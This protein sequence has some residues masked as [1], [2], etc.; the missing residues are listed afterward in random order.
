MATKIVMKNVRL[1]YCHLFE[2]KAARGSDKLKYSASLIIPK[3]HPQLDALKSMIE[4]VIVDKFGK[5]AADKIGLARGGYHTPLGDGDV[6]RSGDPAYA[7]AMYI[8]CSS[9]RKPQV[10]DRMVQPILDE[11]E[12]YSGCYGN[13]SVALFPFDVDTNKGCGCGLNNVQIT[14]L[15]ERLGGAPNADEEFEQEGED[16]EDDID[17]S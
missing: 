2:P 8:N 15:A 13:V 6:D 11:S 9:D 16:E 14:K 4:T 1:S 12:A 7:G 17:M 3:D 10:V 5:K